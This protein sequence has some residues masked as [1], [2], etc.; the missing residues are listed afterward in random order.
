[1]NAEV[2]DQPLSG[3]AGPQLLLWVAR[4][5]AGSG[6][7]M[8]SLAAEM[9]DDDWAEFMRQSFRHGLLPAAARTLTDSGSA[10]PNRVVADLRIAAAANARHSLTLT[11]ELLEVL[12]VLDTAGISAIPWKGPLLAQRA[13]GD[14]GYRSFFDLDILVKPTDLGRA[15]D[16]L[17]DAGFRTEKRMTDE[18]QRAYVDHMGELE[19]VRDSDGLW[20]ELHTAIVPN[21]YSSGRSAIDLWDRAERARLGRSEVWA[22]P[23]ADELEALC[24]HGSK[25]RFERLAWILDVALMAGLLT[26]AEMGTM[27]SVA[28]A[29]G[30]LRMVHLGLLLAAD[31]APEAIPSG[32]LLQSRADAAAVKLAG[33]VRRELFG[34]RHHRTDSLF[35]HAQMLD[36][37]RDRLRYLAN[38]MFRPSGA[39]WESV[40]VP[41]WLFPIY[42]VTRPL[43]LSVKY[44]RRFLRR[45]D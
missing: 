17:F 34:P 21:Y 35:F 30:T 23:L 24:V 9:S 45:A 11:A 14:V 41:P 1:M 28:R 42:A 26:E 38:V 8:P 39:D 31:L 40:S 2:R 3:D 5:A 19:L 32:I 29:H 22:L 37:P 12:H 44:G 15:R 7:R 18:Q 43:R 6:E 13:Y 16:V 36:R 4:N 20:V 33:Q 25:H 10:I 27:L